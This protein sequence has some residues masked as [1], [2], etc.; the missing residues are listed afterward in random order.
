MSRCMGKGD[1]KDRNYQYRWCEST[2]KTSLNVS[3]AAYFSPYATLLPRQARGRDPV[4]SLSSDIAQTEIGDL[5]GA[6]PL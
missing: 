1:G 2:G 4:R 3:L 6:Q 5:R